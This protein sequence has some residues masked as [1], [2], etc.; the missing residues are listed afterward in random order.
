MYESIVLDAHVHGTNT[1]CHSGR[2]DIT[3]HTK[4]DHYKL[5]PFA[6]KSTTHCLIGLVATSVN[7]IRYGAVE[8][9]SDRAVWVGRALPTTERALARR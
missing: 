5:L 6:R 1:P 4:H 7:Q 8:H 2:L 9:V 3:E